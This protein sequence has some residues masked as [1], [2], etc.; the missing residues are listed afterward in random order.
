[1][2]VEVSNWTVFLGGG[3][4]VDELIGSQSPAWLGDTILASVCRVVV[5]AASNRFRR[6]TCRQAHSETAAVSEPEGDLA[7]AMTGTESNQQA[8]DK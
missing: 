1:M 4:E 3:P 8:R 7:L 2:L 5:L 6:R